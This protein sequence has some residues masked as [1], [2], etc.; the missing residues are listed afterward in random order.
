MWGP[1][2]WSGGVWE[3]PGWS[4]G[5]WEP[6][7][8]SGGVWGPPGWSEGVWEPPGGQWG[9]VG[10]LGAS[11]AG[12][13]LL[14]DVVNTHPGLAFLKAAAEFHSRYIT[15]VS[16]GVRPLQGRSV[17]RADLWAPS[18]GHSGLSPGSAG[19]V[20]TAG[21][22]SPGSGLVST[23]S[24]AVSPAPRPPRVAEAAPARCCLPAAHGPSSLAEPHPWAAGPPCWHRGPCSPRAELPPP[25]G[26][27]ADLLHGQQV[28]VRE[29]HL[30]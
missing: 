20:G 12:R 8:G 18:T 3:P 22:E 25:A 13:R 24:S 26:H 9:S 11:R 29:D 19:T 21:S 10:A 15:T 14:Q 23:V 27:P 2:G 16:A 5:V 4:G 17:M 7:G 30:C 6:P 1:P 28:L